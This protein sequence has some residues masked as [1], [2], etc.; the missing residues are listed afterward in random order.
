[1]VFGRF[2]VSPYIQYQTQTHQTDKTEEEE[3]A[4]APPAA[5]A[6]AAAGHCNICH[7]TPATRKGFRSIPSHYQFLCRG[8]L[9]DF[10]V[11]PARLFLGW[12]HGTPMFVCGGCYTDVV[13]KFNGRRTLHEVSLL[14]F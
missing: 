6:A 4:G 9:P 10:D 13:T 7:E 11:S 14:F 1:M 5:A 3:E 8:G 2:V 12:P